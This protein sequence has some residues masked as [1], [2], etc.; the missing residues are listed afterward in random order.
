MT[1]TQRIQ[2]ST[3]AG[4]GLRIER[5]TRHLTRLHAP[6]KEQVIFWEGLPYAVFD[7]FY[8]Y[9]DS[10]ARGG[11]LTGLHKLYP[12]ASKLALSINDFEYAI[13]Q[14]LSK[15]GLMLVRRLDP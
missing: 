11:R 14:A 13:G 6:N 5:V 3:G 9:T 15:A 12:G 8:L 7:G 1:S 2:V 10:S 4:R